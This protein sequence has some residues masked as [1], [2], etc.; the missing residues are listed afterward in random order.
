MSDNQK[1]TPKEIEAI[2]AL[3]DFDLVMLVSEIHDHGWPEARTT[4]RMMPKA[5][6][7]LS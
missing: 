5:K 4:L 3:E 2:R 1:L 6:E 7:I